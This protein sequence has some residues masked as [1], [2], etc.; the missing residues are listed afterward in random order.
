MFAQSVLHHFTAG[1]LVKDLPE[2][3]QWSIKALLSRATPQASPAPPHPSYPGLPQLLLHLVQNMN[4]VWPTVWQRLLQDFHFAH[5]Q[6]YRLA[7]EH[8][9]SFWDTA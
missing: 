7:E 9:T 8:C 5:F 3:V 1:G 6:C 2:D 4:K